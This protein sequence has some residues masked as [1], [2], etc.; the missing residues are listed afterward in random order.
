[1]SSSRQ[2]YIENTLEEQIF[3]E[4]GITVENKDNLVNLLKS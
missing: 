2:L 3:Q 4:L 1:M